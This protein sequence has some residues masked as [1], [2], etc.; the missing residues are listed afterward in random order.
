LMNAVLA[1]NGL[2]A[3]D[4]N[5][6]NNR[7]VLTKKII[8]VLSNYLKG[9]FGE[10]MLDKLRDDIGGKMDGCANEFPSIPDQNDWIM[11]CAAQAEVYQHIELAISKLEDILNAQ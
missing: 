8:V 10:D 9:D 5:N 7:D 2:D 4:F 1:L 11:N 6:E 3:G